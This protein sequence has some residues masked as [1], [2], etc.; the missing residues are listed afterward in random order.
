MENTKNKLFVEGIPSFKFPIG[1]TNIN[2]LEI[3]APYYV[4]YTQEQGFLVFDPAQKTGKKHKDRD[5]KVETDLTVEGAMNLSSMFLYAKDKKA[6]EPFMN[7][8]EFKG[9]VT[10]RL[11]QKIFLAFTINDNNND[12]TVYY[13]S[14]AAC[15]FNA[16]VGDILYKQA[17]ATKAFTVDITVQESLPYNKM[18]A[19]LGDTRTDTPPKDFIPLRKAINIQTDLNLIDVALLAKNNVAAYVKHAQ[20][21]VR[22]QLN[23]PKAT[24]HAPEVTV[25]VAEEDFDVNPKVVIS[26]LKK[27][28][29]PGTVVIGSDGETT[30]APKTVNIATTTPIYAQYGFETMEA[31]TGA[32]QS[33]ALDLTTAKKVSG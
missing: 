15:S 1:T 17:K 7:R 24:T 20:E 6:K 27:L 22:N 4:E 18:T 30:Q 25:G 12:K 8:K 28:E 10:A 5:T 9:G 23:L 19:S 33:G 21:T 31:F 32:L 14:L 2:I 13:G 29:R 3:S 26:Q 11:K 16:Q